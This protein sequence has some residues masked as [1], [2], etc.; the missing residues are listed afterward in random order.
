VETPPAPHEI[1]ALGVEDA[2]ELLTLQRAAYVV[3]AQ[4]H[5]DP[6]LP[7]LTETLAE[8]RAELAAAGVTVL[9]IRDRGRLIATVRLRHDADEPS[10]ARVSRLAV[11]PDRQGEGLGSRLLAEVER[12]AQPQ[13]RALTLFTG[14]RSH[15][16]LSLYARRGYLETHRTDA[17]NHE[18]VHM[19]KPLR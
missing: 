4:A 14:D 19:R 8:V 2:G 13:V 7:P 18:L 17:G 12:H 10:S 1:T 15:R 6:R 11:A 16:N 5:D 9:G 3:E